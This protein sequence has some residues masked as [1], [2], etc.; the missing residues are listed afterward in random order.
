[1]YLVSPYTLPGMSFL[2]FGN[3]QM[4]RV[5]VRGTAVDES[6]KRSAPVLVQAS[7]R[8]I[9]ALTLSH[10]PI[11][12]AST[13]RPGY[14]RQSAAP[15]EQG[16]SFIRAC[17]AKIQAQRWHVKQVAAKEFGTGMHRIAMSGTQVIVHDD[18]VPL[19]ISSCATSLPVSL[20][21]HPIPRTSFRNILWLTPDWFYTGRHSQ[22]PHS[23]A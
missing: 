18:V 3:G 22:K 2:V 9:M 21:R 17:E 13:R 1:M 23:R 20:L 16:R 15:M 19:L 12:R 5:V 11:D 7:N 4:S 8:L 6:M 14:A 10:S